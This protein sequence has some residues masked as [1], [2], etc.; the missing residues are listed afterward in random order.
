MHVRKLLTRWRISSRFREQ[1]DCDRYS[2]FRIYKHLICCIGAAFA[3]ARPGCFVQELPNVRYDTMQCIFLHDVNMK[4][5]PLGREHPLPQNFFI[6]DR[7]SETLNLNSLASYT[8]LV[9]LQ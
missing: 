8:S 5:Q 2:L 1:R 9:K 6:E 7:G 4:P 3:E